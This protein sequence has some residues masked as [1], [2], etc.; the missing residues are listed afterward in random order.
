MPRK[1]NTTVIKPK[2]SPPP[3]KLIVNWEKV[4][5]SGRCELLEEIEAA[6][7]VAMLIFCVF[8]II[9]GIYALWS[10][11]AD[12]LTVSYVFSLEFLSSL[13][14]CWKLYDAI[15]SEIRNIIKKAILSALIEY[16]N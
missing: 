14:F 16:D 9:V 12:T 2:V 10:L 8:I 5:E 11:L 6:D 3:R 1:S 15:T 7:P 13:V 4:E